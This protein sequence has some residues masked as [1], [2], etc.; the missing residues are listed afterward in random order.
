MT[1]PLISDPLDHEL[2]MKRAWKHLRDVDME[3]K[4]WLEGGH[5]S[6]WP[7]GD[8]KAGTRWLASSEKPPLDPIS[9]LIGDCLHNLRSALDNLAFSLASAYTHPLPDSF[10]NTSEFPIFG[11]SDRTG[12]FGLG[13][14]RFHQRRKNGDPAPTSGL[15]KIRGWHPTAQTVAESLQ[16]YHRGKDYGLHPLWVLHDLDRISKHRLLHTTAAH[17]QGITLNPSKSVNVASIA[18]GQII[19]LSGPVETDTPIGT[20][21]PIT[22]IDPSLDVHMEIQP[23]MDIAFGKGTSSAEEEPVLETLY[24]LY[25]Y[26]GGTVIPALAHFL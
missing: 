10:A 9:L 13:R 22:P 23:A 19:S 15:D 25:T 20:F 18:A 1:E 5:Y 7:K 8:P 17:F 3:I 14:G 26:V 2:K 21:P 12:A 6:V 16:P 11:D 4:A 24:S